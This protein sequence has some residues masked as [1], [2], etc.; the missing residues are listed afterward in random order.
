MLLVLIEAK[1]CRSVEFTDDIVL[2]MLVMYLRTLPQAGGGTELILGVVDTIVFAPPPP[3]LLP[4]QSAVRP[5][6]P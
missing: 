3:P 6:A 5:Q 2:I 1:M 4:Y